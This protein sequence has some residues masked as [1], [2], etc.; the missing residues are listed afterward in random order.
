MRITNSPTRAGGRGRL[1]S[2]AAG[3]LGEARMLKQIAIIA[4]LIATPAL[5]QTVP[6]QTANPN[7]VAY[8]QLLA[9]ANGRVAAL[10]GQ[11]GQLQTRVAGAEAMVADLK[12]QLDD[13]K[14]SADAAKA[15]ESPPSPPEPTK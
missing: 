4:A 5:A 8:S 10:M 12:K 1:I 7:E 9:E 15:K 3:K 13:A 14:K 11:N 2:T 6:Q